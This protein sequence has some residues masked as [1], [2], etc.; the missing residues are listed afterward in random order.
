VWLPGSFGEAHADNI[1]FLQFPRVCRVALNFVSFFPL[2][3]GADLFPPSAVKTASYAGVKSFL[4][5]T[6]LSKKEDLTLILISLLCMVL[7]PLQYNLL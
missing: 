3:D 5:L 1:V 2:H 4:L 6:L 7:A